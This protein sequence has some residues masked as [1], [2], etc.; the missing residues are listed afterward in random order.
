MID[1]GDRMVAD[2]PR[3]YDCVGDGS[4]SKVCPTDALN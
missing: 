3:A 2:N 4:C 1:L